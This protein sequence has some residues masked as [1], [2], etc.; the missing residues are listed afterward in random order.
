MPLP[1][2]I[3]G[4]GPVRV[5]CAHSWIAS[6]VTYAP[7]LEHLDPE[8]ATWIFADFRGYGVSDLP[9]P[10]TSITSMGED[11]VGLA[12]SLGW[13]SFHLVGHSMGGQAVQSVIGNPDHRERVLT[14]SLIS[15]VQ[16]QGFPMDEDSEALFSQAALDPKTLEGVVGH[17][18]GGQKSAGF[19]EYAVALSRAT[20]DAQTLGSYLQAWI[21]DD[22]SQG[23]GGYTGPVLVLSGALDPALG[24]SVATEI[25]EQFPDVEL[26]TLDGSGHFPPLEAPSL[27]AA[28]VSRHILADRQPGAE[29]AASSAPTHLNERNPGSST[30]IVE[31]IRSAF[32]G[33]EG[34]DRGP[35]IELL[36][37]DFAFEMSDSLPYGG[38]YIG[39]EEFL[40]YWK[41]VGKAWEYFRYDAHEILECGDTVVVPVKTDALS[42]HGIRMQNEHLFLFKVRDGLVISGRLYADTARGRD[43]IIDGREPQR[44]ERVAFPGKE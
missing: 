5:I 19:A 16:S 6:S 2:Y 26:H 35:L 30:R 3:H 32:T 36:A 11:L 22:V 9:G 20:S 33:F 10:T 27:V 17:L 39:A 15:S 28:L 38:R 43:V 42:T 21:R 44:F 4:H 23:V 14:A 8:L 12:D 41:E 1:Y 18:V 37:P 31:A 34:N 29:T 40:G 13:N 24:P 7:M 25:A